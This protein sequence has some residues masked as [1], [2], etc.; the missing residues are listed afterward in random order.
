[1][2]RRSPSPIKNVSTTFQSG[3]TVREDRRVGQLAVLGHEQKLEHF[4]TPA[5]AFRAAP[6]RNALLSAPA[7]V[8]PPNETP[9]DFTMAAWN[10]DGPTVSHSE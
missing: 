10:G 7:I 5:S 8:K 2:R 1:M 9:R 4:L 6:R 3:T